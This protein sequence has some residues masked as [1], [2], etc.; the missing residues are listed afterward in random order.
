MDAYVLPSLFEGISNSLLEAMAVGLP[1][2][3]SDTGGNPEVV[4]DGQSGLL[5][6]VGDFAR[7]ADLLLRLHG[8]SDLRDGLGQAALERVTEEFALDAMIARY[9]RM[10]QD[11]A[12]GRR[13]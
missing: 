11:L 8:Q 2:I 12:G 7:L 4:V 3:A 5:F 9:E 6:P 13:A 10:Y 1:V